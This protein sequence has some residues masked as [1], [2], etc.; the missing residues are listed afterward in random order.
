MFML[1]AGGKVRGGQVLGA[2]D[3]N[4]TQ[5]ADKGFSPDDVAASFYQNLG[6]DHTKEYHSSTG[7]PITIVR[8]GNPIRELF[9]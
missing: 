3:E 4:A 8:D 7:R 5:P 2:S 6:I 9:A 1:M